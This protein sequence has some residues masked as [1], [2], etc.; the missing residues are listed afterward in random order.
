MMEREG[1]Y[2][3]KG[4]WTDERIGWVLP[5][6]AE[7]WPDREFISFR[8]QRFTYREFGRWVDSV[9]VDL[10]SRGVA[11]RDHILVQLPNTLEALVLQLAAFRMG[12]IACP[13]IPSCSQIEMRH[14]IAD[15]RPSAI[16]VASAH[17]DRQPTREVDEVLDEL[18][19]S[20]RV[21]FAVGGLVDGWAA[22]VRPPLAGLCTETAELPDP[23]PADECCFV[24]HTSGTTGLPKGVM[25]SSRALLCEAR[26]WRLTSDLTFQDVLLCC[27]PMSHLAGVHGG[28]LLPATLGARAVVMPNWDPDEARRLIDRENVTFSLGA[29]VFLIDL[30]QRYEA[31]P[32]KRLTLARFQCGGAAVSPTLVERAHRLGILA[33]KAYGMSET[34]GT[35]SLGRPTDPLA[36]RANTEGRL[37]EG[38][39]ME[40]VDESRRA[41]PPGQVGELRIRTPQGMIGYRD[42]QRTAELMDAEGWIYTGDLGAVTEDGLVRIAGRL[43][44]IINRGGEKFSA[45]EIENAI[46]T[47]PDVASAAVFG[48]P[49][50]RLGETVAVALTLRPGAVWSGHEVMLDHLETIGLAR[51]KR[52]VRWRVLD[53]L[54][55]TPSGKVKKNLLIAMLQSSAAAPLKVEVERQ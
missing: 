4:L 23:L 44:D 55:A 21:K 38:V 49:D 24:L 19:H 15:L 41:L 27:A 29:P 8:S 26:Q 53:A 51:K 5:Q 7:R 18:G 12:A 31:A 13:V 28:F 43:K 11:P 46:A 54:P 16:A 17:G 34:A 39:E 50:D 25:L 48:L 45:L 2:R 3:A 22:V 32:P 9:A 42:P 33:F 1:L 35:C 47:H 10:V 6:A 36:V 52:P 30:V 40:A 20:P 14:I 37:N